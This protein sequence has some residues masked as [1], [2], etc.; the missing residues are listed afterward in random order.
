M[1][2]FEK[3]KNNLVVKK[4]KIRA[5]EF[6]SINDINT[7]GHKSLITGRTKSGKVEHL[8]ITHSPTTRNQRNIKLNENP[9][10]SDKRNSYIL[11]KVQTSNPKYLGKKQEDMQIKNSADKSTVR[12]I[13]KQHKRKGK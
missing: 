4:K 5:G 11:P 10:K 8:P 9:Q 7:R 2:Q 12:H 3:A 13:K 1:N 6:W